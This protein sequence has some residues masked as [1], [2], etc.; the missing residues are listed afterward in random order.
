MCALVYFERGVDVYGWWIGARDS[1][2]LSAYFTLER[3]FSSKPTRF[4]ASEGSDLYGGWKH[5]Y[6]ART[7]EL[8]KPVRVEDAVSHELE[9]VQNMFVTEWLFFDDDPEIAAERAAYDRYN[10]PLGQV[11]MRAQRL[12]KLDKHQAVWLYRSHEFQ[13]DVLAYL[14]RF[15]PL[16]Y[17]ST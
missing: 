3:F 16:D 6:S 4:Y 12:N 9:R 1:E 14:Q 8:D 11:N 17:R 7:T 13:A 15:W 5:L 2:Y 10:M